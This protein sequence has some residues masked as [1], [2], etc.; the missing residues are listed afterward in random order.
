MTQGVLFVPTEEQRRT[1]RA[2]AGYGMPQMDIGT[3]LDIDVGRRQL[4]RV[5]G[6]PR[7]LGG[8]DGGARPRE[9]L[10]DRL[11]GRAVVL[12]R[13]LHARHGLLRAVHGVGVQNSVQIFPDSLG[14]PRPKV[15]TQGRV[16]IRP[17]RWRIWGVGHGSDCQNSISPFGR[18]GEHQLDRA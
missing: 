18:Q 2:M 12:D 3:F 6:P 14:K 17:L 15:S 10:V 7:S 11:A 8:D 4:Q 5:A 1:V 13:P 9:G 16:I